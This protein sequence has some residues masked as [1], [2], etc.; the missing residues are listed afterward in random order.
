MEVGGDTMTPVA[1]RDED[2]ARITG[3]GASLVISAVLALLAADAASVV[4]MLFWL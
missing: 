3:S 1:A 2:F 4:A